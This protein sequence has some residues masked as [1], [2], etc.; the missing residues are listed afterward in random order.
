[1]CCLRLN[2]LPAVL[3]KNKTRLPKTGTQPHSTPGTPLPDLV[4]ND[5]SLDAP[6]NEYVRVQEEIALRWAA[7]KAL[8]PFGLT[9]TTA[10]H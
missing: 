3:A 10:R 8:Q 9:D 6:L 5:R 7:P 1:M 2:R 4:T